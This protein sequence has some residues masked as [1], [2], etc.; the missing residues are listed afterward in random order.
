MSATS[1]KTALD[2]VHETARALGAA[3]KPRALPS[4]ADRNKTPRQRAEALSLA[5]LARLEKMPGLEMRLERIGKGLA[6]SC[7]IKLR[8]HIY[9]RAVRRTAAEALTV[10]WTTAF[11]LNDVAERQIVAFARDTGLV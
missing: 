8:G 11:E 6:H 10:A 3:A 9:A 7:V 2:A 1:H 5:E 4:W